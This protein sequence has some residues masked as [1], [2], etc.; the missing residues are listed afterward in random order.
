MHTRRSSN[1][2]PAPYITRASR[3][4][5]TLLPTLRRPNTFGNALFQPYCCWHYVIYILPTVHKEHGSRLAQ[6]C[7]YHNFFHESCHA[8]K[9]TSLLSCNGYGFGANNMPPPFEKGGW[10]WRRHKTAVMTYFILRMCGTDTFRSVLFLHALQAFL[11]ISHDV[12]SQSRHLMRFIRGFRTTLRLRA[13]LFY[14]FLILFWERLTFSRARNQRP[15]CDF[16]ETRRTSF[17]ANVATLVIT[18]MPQLYVHYNQRSCLV[19]RSQYSRKYFRTWSVLYSQFWFRMCLKYG[20]NKT[21]PLVVVTPVRLYI[22]YMWGDHW[23]GVDPPG[24]SQG[25]TTCHFLR[26]R[27]LPQKIQVLPWG[28]R[29]SVQFDLYRFPPCSTR[30]SSC[31]KLPLLA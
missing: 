13:L 15:R 12:T 8:A 18:Q 11:K 7:G 30:M 6:K 23:W 1:I 24:C 17:N 22:P 20:P 3:Q 27:Q 9:G 4:R 29:S 21:R 10:K 19:H 2:F 25:G 5:E 26:I 28:W 14:K 16:K 31:R